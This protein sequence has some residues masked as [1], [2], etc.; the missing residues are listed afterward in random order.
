MFRHERECRE[1]GASLGVGKGDRRGKKSR[2]V[3][4]REGGRGRRVENGSG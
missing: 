4:K 1:D 2:V 3:R